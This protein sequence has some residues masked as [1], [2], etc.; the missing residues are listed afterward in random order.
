M[1]VNDQT[2][3]SRRRKSYAAALVEVTMTTLG[4][5]LGGGRS[6][7]AKRGRLAARNRGRRAAGPGGYCVCPS[8]GHRVPHVLGEP[9]YDRKCPECGTPMMR[10]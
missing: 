9:C 1:R 10:E 2:V 3:V 8:C 6:E 4:F 5:R 7:D